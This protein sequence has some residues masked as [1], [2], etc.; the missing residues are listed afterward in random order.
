MNRDRAPPMHRL[1]N[2]LTLFRLA[3]APLLALILLLP[4]EGWRWAGLALFLAAA[5]S[6]RLDGALAR[7]L[8]A[9]SEFGRRLDPI[10]DKALIAGAL[11]ALVLTGTIA[12]LHAAAAALILLREIGVL[13]LRDALER[14]G[15]GLPVARLA[16]WKTSAQAASV[17]IL[18]V[19][20]LAGG[21]SGLVHVAGLVLLWAAAGLTLYTGAAYLRRA[22]RVGALQ[23]GKA[24]GKAS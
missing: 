19:A 4:G 7:R 12:G 2:L 20:P 17:A 14:R 15:P 23:P 6:D 18:I 22:R 10:A 9:E 24:S 21:A 13:L 11:I 8:K 16:R 5:A 1:P 3:S